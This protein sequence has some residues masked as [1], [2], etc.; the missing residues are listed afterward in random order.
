MKGARRVSFLLDELTAKIEGDYHPQIKTVKTQIFKIYGH[1]IV[2]GICIS[3][4]PVIFITRVINCWRK[5][6]KT[7][8]I[9]NKTVK[10]RRIVNT[11]S[12][13]V[14]YT[15]RIVLRVESTLQRSSAKSIYF[16]EKRKFSIG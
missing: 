7:K 1:D 15:Y 13:I 2:I 6:G 12:Y 4:I 11:I 16:T 14:L 8:Q 10:R 5:P 9:D 3:K